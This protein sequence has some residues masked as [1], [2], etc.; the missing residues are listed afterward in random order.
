MTF[1]PYTFELV[2]GESDIEENDLSQ[3]YIPLEAI[4]DLHKLFTFIP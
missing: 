1:F 3:R 2:W 4:I